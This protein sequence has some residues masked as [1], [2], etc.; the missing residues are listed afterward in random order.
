[1]DEL[2]KLYNN[3]KLGFTSPIRFY[4][5]LQANGYK[6]TLK[7]VN[8]FMKNH[9]TNQIHTELKQIYIPIQNYNVR[10][11]FQ[12]DLLVLIKSK[13]TIPDVI[14][15]VKKTDLRYIL[16]VI[17]TFSRYADCRFMKD[18]K[19]SST[20]EAL[21][22]IL[23]DMGIPQQI[24]VD[25]GNEFKG[26]FKKVCDEDDI[27]LTYINKERDNDYSTMIVERFN[28]TLIGYIKRYKTTNRKQGINQI[29]AQLPN[30]I[31]N[32]NHSVNSSIGI[33]PTEAFKNN[34][35]YNERELSDKDY[36][37][38]Q[39]KVDDKVRVKNPKT[40][41]TKGREERYTKEIY[42]IVEK[43]GNQYRLNKPFDNREWFIYHNLIK[44]KR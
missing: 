23:E 1:M 24:I 12:I 8:E 18:K 3:P 30:F 25:T 15:S 35:V 38:T 43:K 39:F 20:A 21:K 10:E 41:Y 4:K 29:A 32:Y 44:I 17:D 22:S 42:T 34:I 33:T 5:N 13:A 37:K 28:K 36:E 16:C 40:I 27:R 19:A 11:Q 14:Q 9:S 31:Y 7:Q 26:E 2:L 6:Y